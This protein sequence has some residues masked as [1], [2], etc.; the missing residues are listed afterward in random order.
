MKYA[1]NYPC[2]VCSRAETGRLYRT[3]HRFPDAIARDAWVAKGGDF[4]SS[5][6]YRESVSRREV[7]A[8]I[9]RATRNHPTG[10]PWTGNMDGTENEYLS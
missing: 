2:G 9:A 3:V 6:N 4:R 8:E 10:E 7:A 1:V 5:R